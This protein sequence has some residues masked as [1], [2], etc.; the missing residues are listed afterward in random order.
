MLIFTILNEKGKSIAGLEHPY[1]GISNITF[2]SALRKYPGHDF[3][4]TTLFSIM[5]TI[6]ELKIFM[7]LIP[8]E[9]KYFRSL[10][11]GFMPKMSISGPGVR[12]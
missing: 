10:P 9:E 12:I 8:L 1:M 4:I 2:H 7:Q 5:L 6:Q 11:L 3:I